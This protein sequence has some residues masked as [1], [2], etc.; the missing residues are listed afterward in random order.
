MAAIPRGM[1]TV[2]YVR[3]QQGLGGGDNATDVITDGNAITVLD[4]GQP[5]TRHD[6]AHVLARG[7]SDEDVCENTVGNLAGSGIGA[8]LNPV[9]AFVLDSVTSL[10][11]LVGSKQTKKW[12]FLKR[13]FLPFLANEVFALLNE[14]EQQHAHDYASQLSFSSFEIQDEVITDLLRPSSRGLSVSVSAEEGVIVPGLHK[15]NVRDENSF[16]R[17]FVESCENR[18]SHTLPIGASIDTSAA[19]WEIA[20]TQT[21]GGDQSSTRCFSKL[22]VLDLP[23]VDSLIG[24]NSEIRQLES[25][26]LHKSLMAFVDVARRLSTPAKAALAPFRASKLTHYLSEMLGGNAIVV[27][28]GLISGGEAACTRKTLDVMGALTSAVHYPVGGKELTDVLQG[29]LGKYRAMILQ[30]QDEIQN[31]APIGERAPE[32]S[33][34]RMNDLQRELANAQMERNTAKEDRARIFEMME[35]LKAKYSTLVNEKASQSQEL[36][37]AE[38]D[39]LS[40]ARALVELKLEHSARQEQTEKEKFELSSALLAAKNEIFDLDAQLLLARTEASTLKDNNVELE[41]RVQ[42]DQEEFAAAR[43]SLQEIREQLAREVDKNLEVGAE[44]L[45]LINQKDVLQRRVD[46]L[47]QKLDVA[48]VKLSAVTTQENDMKKSQSETLAALRAR[49]DENSQLKRSLADVELDVKRVTL[50]L[51]HLQQDNERREE[52]WAREREAKDTALQA[53]KESA[54]KIAAYNASRGGGAGDMDVRAGIKNEQKIRDMQRDMKRTEDDLESVLEEKKMLDQE[55]VKSR[56]TLRK[57]LASDIAGGGGG[58]G[59]VGEPLS[60]AKVDEIMASL[61]GSFT[62]RE[63]QLNA[64]T[65]AAI[66]QAATLKNGLRFLYDKYQ[67][68]LDG[69]EENLPNALQPEDPVLNEQI[70]IGEDALKHANAMIEEASRFE[71]EAIRERIQSAE[72]ALTQEQE[73]MNLILG[74]YKKNLELAETRLAEA[75][76]KEADMAIQIQQLV[77]KGPQ[78]QAPPAAAVA[79]VAAGGQGMADQAQLLK[80]MQEQFAAQMQ[81]LQSI[82]QQGAVVADQ[83]MASPMMIELPQQQQS[84]AVPEF[85]ST[86]RPRTPPHL[87]GAVP[88]SLEEAIAYIQKLEDGANSAIVKQLREVE[89]R[90]THLASRVLE[91]ETELKT[92]QDYMKTTVLEYKKKLQSLQGQLS[93]GTKSIKGGPIKGGPGESTAL[94]PLK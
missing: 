87:K 65:D 35:L 32:L 43:A 5:S 79:A 67:K 16:R 39:K 12:Q 20:L 82:K 10:V 19:V 24:L 51:E 83:P 64:R 31:G 56:E 69:M 90:A 53:A 11:I 80:A 71:R 73:R 38:E 48:N 86:P 92:Y 59:A 18:A 61:V 76:R 23:C 13:V 44:L 4:P 26:T 2:S 25:L 15:E 14:K 37:K 50:E 34:K 60:S 88:S 58:A 89:K 93:S 9:S 70:L 63:K 85:E 41:I 36:I 52:E 68:A 21:E 42:K 55:L 27:G 91:L 46:D 77:S 57:K 74:T 28:L 66:S 7:M 3:I 45:T 6:V 62:E 54:N 40:V 72:N 75:R 1:P 22:I 84:L 49:E 29:L 8:S 81:Q 94:P 33:E 47:Q 30:L 78:Q 17:M